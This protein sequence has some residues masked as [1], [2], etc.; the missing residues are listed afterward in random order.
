MFSNRQFVALGLV[1]TGFVGGTILMVL[2][3]RGPQGIPQHATELPDPLPLPEFSLV[4]QRGAA[5]DK[6]SFEGHESL[7]FFGFTHCPDICPA[8]LQQL[9]LTRRRM[10]GPDGAGFPRIVLISVDPERDSPAA[11]AAYVEHFGAGITGVTG[12]LEEL[13]R[14]TSALGIYF[15]K[16]PG[17][18]GGYGV[19]H[20]AVVLLINEHAE[21]Q[22]VFRAPHAVDHF[23]ADLPLL[24]GPT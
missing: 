7:V 4:D 2:A 17:A 20:S 23:V 21:F 6:A 16:S 8:T 9:A 1:V 19:D 14:L 13:R 24:T 22:A 15:E 12:E 10:A 3:F 18:D 5:F 11:L